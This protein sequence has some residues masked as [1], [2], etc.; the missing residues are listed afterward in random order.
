MGASNYK[1]PPVTRITNQS[2]YF[3]EFQNKTLQ[4]FLKNLM[5][6]INKQN[7]KTAGVVFL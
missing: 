1:Y 4:H 6:I 3:P 7:F 5:A 2:L